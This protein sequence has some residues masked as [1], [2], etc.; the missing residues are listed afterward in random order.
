MIGSAG[1]PAYYIQNILAKKLLPTD[2]TKT[3][4]TGN[5]NVGFNY[6]FW[7]NSDIID[8]FHVPNQQTAEP[9]SKSYVMSLL[10]TR[11]IILDGQQVI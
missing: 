4:V 2:T 9:S 6:L 11:V 10:S 1:N 7:H 5:Q 3:F 8:S